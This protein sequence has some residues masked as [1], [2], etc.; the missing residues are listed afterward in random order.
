MKI[1]Y[2]TTTIP[3][4]I[5][6]VEHIKMLIS[7]GHTV[8]L[9]CNLNVG[10]IRTD[11]YKSNGFIHHQIPFSRT[12][13]SRDNISAYTKLKQLIKEGKYDIVHTHT[14][15]A[16]VIV[17]LVCRKL[18]KQGIK[19]FYTAHGFHF[20]KGAPLLNWLTYY[21]V[22]KLCSKWTDKLITINQEDYELAKGKMYANRTELIPGVGVGLSRFKNRQ[23]NRTEIRKNL[24]VLQNKKV[25]IYIAEL[26]NNKNQTS[27][28]DMMSELV[29]IR[30]DVIL[31]LVGPGANREE[32]EEKAKRLS[33]DDS[34]IFTGLIKDIADVLSSADVCVP[35]SIREGFGINIIEAMACRV[36]VVAYDNRGH[37]TI[38][39]DGENGFLVKHGDFKAMADKVVYLLDNP[40]VANRIVENAYNHAEKYSTENAVEAMKKIY[41]DL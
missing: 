12:P 22:E 9:A 34:V 26:N 30:K 20:Y 4:M 14:P 7:C 2:V 41:F 10:T 5:F 23:V 24:G 6:F 16:S 27:L 38:I 3:T 15:N 36:P 28:L 8:E 19:V 31:L 29:K 18:R 11:F 40:D 13:L 35:S 17:R 33:I 21:P 37:R 39:N 32:L 1:L 25:L